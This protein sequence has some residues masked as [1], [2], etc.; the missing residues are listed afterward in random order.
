MEKESL[1]LINQQIWQIIQ[2]MEDAESDEAKQTLE[3][4]LED[5][6]MRADTIHPILCDTITEIDA[7]CD[8]YSAEIERC[9]KRKKSLSDKKDNI[10]SILQNWVISKGGKV[11]LDTKTL[12]I[13]KNPPSL[14]IDNEQLIIDKLPVTEIKYSIVKAELK[15]F[16]LE[17]GTVLI[18]GEV[19]A[20]TEQ[21]DSLVIK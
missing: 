8:K 19:V 17:N 4:V 16:L 1:Y 11:Q 21:S 14:K 12:S 18:D 9:Q 7:Q 13:R 6:R 3:Q 15:K 2:A 5:L 20:H 10:K